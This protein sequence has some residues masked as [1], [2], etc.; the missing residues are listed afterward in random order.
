MEDKKS[1]KN[2]KEYDKQEF[3]P[4]DIKLIL[5]GDSAAGKS[6]YF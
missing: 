4:C 2:L 3:K 5:L 1:K 6:K